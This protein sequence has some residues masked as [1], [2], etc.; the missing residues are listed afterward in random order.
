MTQ[1]LNSYLGASPELRQLSGKAEQLIAL[2][3][4]Y[5]RLA[6]ISL[7]RSSHVLQ[8]EQQ[9]LTLAANNGAT[10]AKLRQLAPELVG[11][12]QDRGCEVTRIQVRVQVAQSP[13]ILASIP[14]SLSAK[15]RERLTELAAGLP[16]SPLRSALQR[17]ARK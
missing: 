13:S 4:L 16:D 9:I 1:R 8:L 7:T 11:L 17:L 10:A 12:L 15:G 14:A 3:R 2:Q 6:P 5:E